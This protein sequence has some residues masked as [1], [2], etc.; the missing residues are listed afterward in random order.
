MSLKALVIHDKDNMCNLIGPGSKGDQVECDIAKEA[1]EAITLL[2]DIPANHKFARIDI[3]TG[4]TIWKYGLS[5]GT[6][7]KDIA[8]GEYVHAHNI[9]SNYGRG[10]LKK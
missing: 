4:A 10:D 6:A 3:K 8:Q 9:D 5:I 2:E 7:S 1:T